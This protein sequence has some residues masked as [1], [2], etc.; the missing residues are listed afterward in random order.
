MEGLCTAVELA[1]ENVS[2]VLE[3]PAEFIYSSVE[4]VLEEY[5]LIGFFKL[6]K[7]VV[8]KLCKF[9]M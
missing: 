3:E 9:L 2:S 7:E 4:Q 8:L 1:A 6:H 5:V